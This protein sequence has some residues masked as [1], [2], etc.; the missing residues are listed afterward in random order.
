[1]H[2]SS[3]NPKINHDLSTTFFL[4]DE[5]FCE[6]T[7]CFTGLSDNLHLGSPIDCLQGPNNSI[8]AIS[9][10]ISLDKVINPSQ[11]I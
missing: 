7:T 1:M 5:E 11:I 8:G 2:V 6:A 3:P 4:E 9:D 10:T